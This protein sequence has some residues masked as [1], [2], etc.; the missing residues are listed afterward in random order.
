[1]PSTCVHTG[2]G[3]LPPNAALP[4]QPVV[5]VVPFH[6][7]PAPATIENVSPALLSPSR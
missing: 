3:S 6:I 1:V 5:Q 4:W 2:V 7:E